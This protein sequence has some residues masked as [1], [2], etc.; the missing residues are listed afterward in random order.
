MNGYSATR[1]AT[2]ISGPTV[3]G[4]SLS[5]E[6]ISRPSAVTAGGSTSIRLDVVASSVTVG[7]GITVALQTRA[8]GTWTTVA[9]SNA[10]KSITANG[11]TTLSLLANRAADQADLPLGEQVR[12]ILTTGVGSSIQIDNIEILQA[13]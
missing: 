6:V 1:I 11:V 12:V 3:Y 9:S 7:G 4:A 13:L 5:A 10:S 2:N 8:G